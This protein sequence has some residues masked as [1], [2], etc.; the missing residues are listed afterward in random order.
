[1]SSHQNLRGS[2]PLLPL[3]PFMDGVKIIRVGGRL[4]NSPL[5]Y[6]EKFTVLLPPTHHTTQLI[7]LSCHLSFLHPGGHLTMASIRHNGF[8]VPHLNLAINKL[9]RACVPCRK[10]T[11]IS[12]HGRSS[13]RKVGA[14]SPFH[15]SFGGR[16]L[17]LIPSPRRKN[18][19]ANFRLKEVVG[20]IIHMPIQ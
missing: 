1:M 17:R 3:S 20:F 15:S 12:T 7:I 16:F 4:R 11:R 6:H 2:D 5:P 18:Y 13:N 14:D 8:H 10:M 19:Q 9:L